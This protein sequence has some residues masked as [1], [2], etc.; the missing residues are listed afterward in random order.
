MNSVDKFWVRLK[1]IIECYFKK[2]RKLYPL[3]L[4]GSKLILSSVT[5]FPVL[6]WTLNIVLPEK[7]IVSGIQFDSQ[8]IS[9]V[10]YILGILVFF[11][12][13]FLIFTDV[14]RLGEATRSTSKALITGMLGTNARFPT[15]ILSRPERCCYRVWR[16]RRR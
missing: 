2:K 1:W 9:S 3:A 4:M 13:A 11:I 7:F 10:N 15:E 16:Q 14:K 12:G 8:S 5:F 6:G